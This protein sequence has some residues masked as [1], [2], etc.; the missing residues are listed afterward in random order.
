MI[1]MKNERVTNTHGKGEQEKI[2]L[3]PN[4]IGKRSGTMTMV[5][6]LLIQALFSAPHQKK[7][8]LGYAVQEFFFKIILE[9]SINLIW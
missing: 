1:P 6:T 7:K 3:L 2:P 8:F 5:T 9:T 4:K